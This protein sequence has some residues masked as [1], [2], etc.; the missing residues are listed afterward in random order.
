MM[1]IIASETIHIDDVNQMSI[2][3]PDK[4]SPVWVC[5]FYITIIIRYN[6][7]N[8]YNCIE[9]FITLNFNLKLHL[10]NLF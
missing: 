2:P 5:L 3:T 6:N 1:M 8:Y 9:I 7:N 10:I 4:T